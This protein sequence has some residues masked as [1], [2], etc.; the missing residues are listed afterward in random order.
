MSLVDNFDLKD[1]D[2][3]EE[4]LALLREIEDEMSTL[5]GFKRGAE[6]KLEIL[7]NGDAELL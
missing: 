2:D 3:Y 4:V 5:R 1:Y 7:Q 6:E